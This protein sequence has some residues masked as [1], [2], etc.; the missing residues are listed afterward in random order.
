M[1]SLAQ[2]L[3][4]LPLKTAGR[5]DVSSVKKIIGVG[6]NTTVQPFARWLRPRPTQHNLSNHTD[7]PSLDVEVTKESKTAST[8][9]TRRWSQCVA[10][11]TSPLMRCTSVSEANID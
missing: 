7:S 10:W 4:P 2:L 3:F 6:P 9:C 11:S 8:K 5:L 1:A